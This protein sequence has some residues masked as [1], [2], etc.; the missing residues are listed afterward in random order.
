MN[1]QRYSLFFSIAI[2]TISITS[3]ASK[4]DPRTEAIFASKLDP[5]TE[6]IKEKAFKKLQQRQFSIRLAQ[7]ATGSI[8]LKPS[9]QE[10]VIREVQFI[11]YDR[12]TP[13]ITAA[14][15]SAITVG[16]VASTEK[17]LQ[18]DNNLAIRAGHVLDIRDRTMTPMPIFPIHSASISKKAGEFIELLHR[19][20]PQCIDQTGEDGNTPLM[21]ALRQDMKEAAETFVA[22]GSNLF[23][24]NRKKETALKVAM[25][26]EQIDLAEMIAQKMNVDFEQFKLHYKAFEA[27]SS[28]EDKAFSRFLKREGFNVNVRDELGTPLL[29]HALE[30]G[31]SGM[32]QLLIA[33]GADLCVLD[34]K[35]NGVDHYATT[36]PMQTLLKNLRKK[37]TPLTA[38]KTPALDQ[39]PSMPDNDPLSLLKATM[40]VAERAQISALFLLAQNKLAAVDQLIQDQGGAHFA[41]DTISVD[42][43]RLFLKTAKEAPDLSTEA[44][45]FEKQLANLQPGSTTTLMQSAHEKDNQELVDLLHAKYGVP[46]IAPQAQLLAANQESNSAASDVQETQ[47]HAKQKQLKNQRRKDNK[48]AREKLAREQE[49]AAQKL[50]TELENEWLVMSPEENAAHE[51]YLER[52]QSIEAFNTSALELF[53]KSRAE[54]ERQLQKKLEHSAS[55]FVDSLLE[56]VAGEIQHEQYNRGTA[57]LTEFCNAHVDRAYE[58]LDAPPFSEKPE[59][60]QGMQELDEYMKQGS[61][62]KK[63]NPLSNR[64]HPLYS[65]IPYSARINFYR[66]DSNDD[67]LYTTPQALQRRVQDNLAGRNPF[68]AT[69]LDIVQSSFPL[70]PNPNAIIAIPFGYPDRQTSHNLPSLCTFIQ[71]TRPLTQ[72]RFKST[73]PQQPALLP[74]RPKERSSAQITHSQPAPESR[75]QRLVLDHHHQSH[76]AALAKVPLQ[77]ENRGVIVIK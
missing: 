7:T 30:H 71:N 25:K 42:S 45:L 69:R 64:H 34:A 27:I 44:D 65:Y 18:K 72:A 39:T 4:P 51:A 41:A 56:N 21:H 63:S 46:L 47:K 59:F 76:A 5:R 33:K 40:P 57:A 49:I 55:S 24:I 66:A 38:A 61:M 16:N 8:N 75:N 13:A 9:E 52:E 6:A 35:G 48:A 43:L 28:G 77:E 32:V 15:I 20:N 10:E 67:F 12:K 36:K 23:K 11:Q 31:R 26:S 19:Y 53:N 73:L 70:P 2:F 1:T 37:Q 3:F 29:L 58:R 74:Q 60:L 50:E 68:L 62:P 54:Q 14:L 17:I 22:L